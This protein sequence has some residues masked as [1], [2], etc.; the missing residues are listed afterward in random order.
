MQVVAQADVTEMMG[1]A[2][3]SRW[4]VASM[5]RL[6]LAKQISADPTQLLQIPMF[7]QPKNLP[8]AGS[9]WLFNSRPSAC[10]GATVDSPRTARSLMII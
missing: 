10:F 7:G 8:V 4:R 1:A 9:R 5:L 3:I 6:V 2:A